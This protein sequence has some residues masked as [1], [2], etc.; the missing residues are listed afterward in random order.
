MHTM[1]LEECREHRWVCKPRSGRSR[2]A[3]RRRRLH[4]R[5]KMR[6]ELPQRREV[7]DE[8]LGQL[9]CVAKARRQ[10]VAELDGAERIEPSLHQR[11]VGRDARQ[12]ISRHLAHRRQ[13]VHRACHSG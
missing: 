1:S 7:E 3:W 4:K 10:L 2:R 6:L 13:Y 9:G 11:H 12:Q 5:A 8:R